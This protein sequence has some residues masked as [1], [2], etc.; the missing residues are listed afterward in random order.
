RL[1]RT[2]RADG[3]EGCPFRPIEQKLAR[4]SSTFEARARG[5]GIAPRVGTYIAPERKSVGT[6][7]GHQQYRAMRE[8]QLESSRVAAETRGVTRRPMRATCAVA[9]VAS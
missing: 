5:F 4:R 8:E 2:T 7:R 9:T 6:R 3:L 1:P